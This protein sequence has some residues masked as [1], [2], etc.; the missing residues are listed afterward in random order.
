MSRH[1]GCQERI[2]EELD[3][4][5]LTGAIPS[6]DHIVSYA[7]AFQLPY[8]GACIRESLRYSSSITQM[9]RKAPPETGLHLRGTYIP[10]GVSVSTSSWIVGRDKALYGEDAFEFR[11]SR[12]TEASPDLFKQMETLDFAFGYGARKCLGKHLAFLEIFKCVVE[13]SPPS[14]IKHHQ[15]PPFTP[16]PPPPTKGKGAAAGAALGKDCSAAPREDEVQGPAGMPL[17]AVDSKHDRAT[18][19]YRETGPL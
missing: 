13:V 15:I 4:A 19:R 5:E 14:A 7:Q 3:R 6:R 2:H 8:V 12:W 18:V 1:P 10:P 17:T 11:P 16:S 9:G